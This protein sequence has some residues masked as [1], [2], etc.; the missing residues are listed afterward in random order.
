MKKPANMNDLF[1][2]LMAAVWSATFILYSIAVISQLTQYGGISVRSFFIL[3]SSL[4]CAP[5]SVFN[6]FKLI[7]TNFVSLGNLEML[8]KEFDDL[9][10]KIKADLESIKDG[11]WTKDSRGFFRRTE[12]YEQMLNKIIYE[13]RSYSIFNKDLSRRFSNLYDQ[14]Y[15]VLSH[16]SD[17]QE[18]LRDFQE[19]ETG[20]DLELRD[21]YQKET[22][23]AQEVEE[24]FIP[25]SEIKNRFKDSLVEFETSHI[26]AFQFAIE[27]NA[28]LHGLDRSKWLGRLARMS[29]YITSEQEE[30]DYFDQEE[31]LAQEMNL[32]RIIGDFMIEFNEAAQIAEVKN[33]ID[34]LFSLCEKQ[35]K[36]RFGLAKEN[37]PAED[38]KPQARNEA[39]TIFEFFIFPLIISLVSWFAKSGKDSPYSGKGKKAPKKLLETPLD[40]EK[41]FEKT[42]RGGV[43]LFSQWQKENPDLARRAEDTFGYFKTKKMF[44]T[45]L[46]CINGARTE[47]IINTLKTTEGNLKKAAKLLGTT[48]RELKMELYFLS[49]KSRALREVLKQYRIPRKPKDLK[50]PLGRRLGRDKTPEDRQPDLPDIGTNGGF[51]RKLLKGDDNTWGWGIGDKVSSFTEEAEELQLFLRDLSEAEGLTKNMVEKIFSISLSGKK[52]VM[53]FDSE[54]GAIQRVSPLGVIRRLNELKKD[55]R[56]KKLLK[57]LIIIETHSKKIHNKIQKY[58]GETNTEIMIFARN[59]ERERLKKLESKTRISSFYIDDGTFSLNARYPLL[60]IVTIALGKYRHGL[61]SVLSDLEKLQVDLKTLNIKA[62]DVTQTGALIFTLLDKPKEF[63]KQELEPYYANLKRLLIAA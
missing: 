18:A 54:I 56:F 2:R 34:N 50:L 48:V 36:N 35:G 17:I 26:P 1:W 19:M 13:L 60:E 63:D 8:E 21:T 45:V 16:L 10:A 9:Y 41:L 25:L 31:T 52:L 15:I 11:S 61:D 62:I 37:S 33:L 44:E 20:L 27:E 55:P 22:A 14:I 6:S 5:I 39:F 43:R 28:R 29:E 23:F 24:T 46:A 40:V 42:I 7:R 12:S 32:M 59:S 57:N 51:G 58:F 30:L 4:I 53:V 47:D 38:K 49:Q 3:V